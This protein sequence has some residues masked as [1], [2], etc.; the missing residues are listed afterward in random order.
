MIKHYLHL[1][2]WYLPWPVRIIL[3]IPIIFLAGLW[4]TICELFIAFKNILDPRIREQK[5]QDSKQCIQWYRKDKNE[6]LQH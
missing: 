4:F 6:T 5:I 2:F 1:F 3:F